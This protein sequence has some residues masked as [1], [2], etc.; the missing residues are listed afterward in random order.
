MDDV[1]LV[2]LGELQTAL[3]DEVEADQRITVNDLCNWHRDWLGQVYVWAGEFRSVNMQKGEFPFAAVTQ[4]PK[5]MSEFDSNYLSRFTPCDGMDETRLT[6]A[7]A[8]CHVELIIIH[9]FREGNGRL[10]RVLATVMALQAGAPLLDF[11]YLTENE[12]HYISAIHH[13]HAGD[14]GPMKRVYSEVLR[15]SRNVAQ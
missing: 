2:L 12:A 13:G 4:I 14:Y 15:V 5:L 11:T 7:L 1:E 9:P 8:N 6:E 3:L 10:A